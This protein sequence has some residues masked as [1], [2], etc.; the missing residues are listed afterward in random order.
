L[1]NTEVDEGPSHGFGAVRD[2]QA[3]PITIALV[4]TVYVDEHGEAGC[5]IA[6]RSKVNCE[7]FGVERD[8]NEGL[9]DAVAVADSIFAEFLVRISELDGAVEVFERRHRQECEVKI[10]F[11]GL[12]RR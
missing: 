2:D 10:T 9:D 8:R 1:A 7:R 11:A 5:H 6:G 4:D 12:S 3:L